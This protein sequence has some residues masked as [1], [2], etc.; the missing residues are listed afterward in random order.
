[1]NPNQQGYQQY[2]SPAPQYGGQY[3]PQNQPQFVQPQL[4]T[5]QQPVDLDR[6]MNQVDNF[7]NLSMNQQ[8]PRAPQYGPPSEAPPPPTN[9][10]EEIQ[11][12]KQENQTL[13]EQLK[14]ISNNVNS[15]TK[16]VLGIDVPEDIGILITV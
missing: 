13:K 4:S 15:F 1:M 8:R 14:L 10:Q 6:M 11:K 5:V 12:L 3:T 7:T 16:T 2:N 9:L